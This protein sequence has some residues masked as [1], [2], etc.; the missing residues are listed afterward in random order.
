MLRMEVFPT[1]DSS[2]EGIH[3]SVLE[4]TH[5]RTFMSV[6]LI[7]GGREPTNYYRYYRKPGAN[8]AMIKLH[9]P[10]LSSCFASDKNYINSDHAV[11]SY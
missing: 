11:N 6:N 4:M 8:C 9:K 1:N 3:A 7:F 10:K 2:V 5:H